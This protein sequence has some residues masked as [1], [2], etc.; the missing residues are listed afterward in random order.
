MLLNGDDFSV[1]KN[2]EKD[3][4]AAPMGYDYWYQPQH[5]VMM[6]TEWGAPHKIFSGFNLKDCLEEGEFLIGILVILIY[7]ILHLWCLL[8]LC[9]MGWRHICFSPVCPSVRLSVH[10]SVCDVYF[11]RDN[12]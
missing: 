10:P 11:C 7:T 4:I 1:D 2:W 9:P 12:L 5:N 8:C 6:S 3:C